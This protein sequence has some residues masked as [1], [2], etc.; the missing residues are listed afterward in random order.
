MW[1][2]ILASGKV[3][4][5][6]NKILRKKADPFHLAESSHQ[7]RKLMITIYMRYLLKTWNKSRILNFLND[8]KI[9]QTGLKRKFN[10]F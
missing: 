9:Q 1:K 5:S 6:R 2:L 3:Q 10:N 7:T 8:R 4:F